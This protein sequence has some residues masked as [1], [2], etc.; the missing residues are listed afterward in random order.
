MRILKDYPDWRDQYI[1]DVQTAERELLNKGFIVQH[2]KSVIDIYSLPAEHHQTFFVKLVLDHKI[3]K[4]VFA[5][6]IQRSVWFSDPL[7]MYTFDEADRF[8]NDPKRRGQIICGMKIV[9][10]TFADKMLDLV[11]RISSNQPASAVNPSENSYF[12][13]IRIYDLGKVSREFIFTDASMLRLS[14]NCN[15]EETIAELDNLH[16]MIEKIIGRGSDKPEVPQDRAA[17]SSSA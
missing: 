17:G 5:K 3:F 8:R 16:F 1:V 10:K 6:P 14:E 7:Y 11:E 12:T 15:A 2:N 9:E 4:I 13:A